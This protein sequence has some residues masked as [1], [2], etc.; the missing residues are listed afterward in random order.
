M[1]LPGLGQGNMLLTSAS[2]EAHIGLGFDATSGMTPCQEAE[3]YKLL[4]NQINQAAGT[5]FYLPPYDLS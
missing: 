3:N 5:S 2:L 1:Y 4:T